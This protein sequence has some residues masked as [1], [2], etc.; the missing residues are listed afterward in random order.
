MKMTNSDKQVG[1]P[2][3]FDEGASRLVVCNECFPTSNKV[4]RT[5]TDQRALASG[6][7]K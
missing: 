5:N 6:G 3:R 2:D 4:V 7:A 1:D